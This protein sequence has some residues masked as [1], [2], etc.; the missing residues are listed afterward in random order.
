MPNNESEL[1]ARLAAEARNNPDLKPVE[2][3][4][5]LYP[6]D[7]DLAITHQRYSFAVRQ[8]LAGKRVPLTPAAERRDLY[9]QFEGLEELERRLAAKN[10]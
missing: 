9:P 4:R 7:A 5:D 10:R 3:R 8:T 2:Q 6:S 1:L